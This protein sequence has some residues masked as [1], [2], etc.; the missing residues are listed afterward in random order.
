MPDIN[1]L[2]ATPRRAL[3]VFYILDTSGSME[4][5]KIAQL[6]KAMEEC[7]EALKDLAQNQADAELKIA[8]MQFDTDCQWVTKQGPV[9]LEDFEWEPL[10]IGGLTSMGAALRELDSKLSR[11]EFLQ[12]ITGA[13]MPV[14]IFMTDGDPTDDYKGPLAEIR[15]N[16]W[17]QR[18]TKIG[19]AIGDGEVEANVKVIAEIVGNKEAVIKTGD[20]TLFR[21]LMKFVS[22]RASMLA[23]SSRTTN[24]VATGADIINDAKKQLDLSD[25]EVSADLNEPYDKEPE[26]PKSDD[27]GWDE[28]E[29]D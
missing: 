25:D 19:F 15:Q 29:W 22:V 13:F 16:K 14:I 11:K 4:G 27:G 5:A 24:N 17:Y 26:P 18:A 21:K 2:K 9:S 7:T 8:V 28:A 1:E 23:S 6:N 10:E 12:S 20:L 3:H